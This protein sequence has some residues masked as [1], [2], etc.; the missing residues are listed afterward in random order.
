MTK[1]AAARRM[2]PEMAWSVVAD[3]YLELAHRTIG[4]ELEGGTTRL[5]IGPFQTEVDIDAATSALAEAARSLR[6]A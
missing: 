6:P 4:T 5:S 2:A 3:A 1:T